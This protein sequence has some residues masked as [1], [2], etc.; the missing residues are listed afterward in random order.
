MLA[1][2]APATPVPA[3]RRDRSLGAVRDRRAFPD[4]LQENDTP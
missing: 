3:D 1:R 4:L 2:S